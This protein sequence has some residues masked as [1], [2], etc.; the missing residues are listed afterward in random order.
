MRYIIIITFLVNLQNTSIANN[1]A[2]PCYGCHQSYKNN[3]EKSIPSILGL[4]KNYFIQ[5]FKDYRSFKR[6][7]YLMHIISK[8]YNEREIEALATYFSKQENTDD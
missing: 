8:G 4:D 2:L 7:N 6:E 5:A 1:I 3:S